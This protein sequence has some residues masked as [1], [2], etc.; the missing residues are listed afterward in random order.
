[1]ILS[2]SRPGMACFVRA[3]SKSR[4]W[5]WPRWCWVALAGPCASSACGRCASALLPKRWAR[6]RLLLSIT[7]GVLAW[8]QAAAQRYDTNQLVQAANR[9]S[10][11][12]FSQPLGSHNSGDNDEVHQAFER[13]RMALRQ[14]TITK[15]YLDSV[16]NS[17][18][19]AVFVTTP[20]GAIRIANEAACRLTG[21]A[22]ARSAGNDGA[23]AAR[24]DPTPVTP[25]A[26][27]HRARNRRSRHAHRAPARPSR[28]PSS[29]R[30]S[31][32]TT[33]SLPARSTWRATSPSA[34]A[35][36]GASATWRATTR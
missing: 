18:S 10:R 31:P 19:D 36:S 29:P 28:C 14:T 12:D 5:C 32:P 4:I 25:I 33:R 15:N 20:T 1:M 34:S 3:H 13:M 26:V 35:P 7:A 27:R 21:Y 8:K 17:M 2:G 30:P 24:R 11:G 9:I 23:R 16:L 22:E 6:S